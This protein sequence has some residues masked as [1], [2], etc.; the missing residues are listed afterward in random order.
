[1]TSARSSD[2]SQPVTRLVQRHGGRDFTLLF[3]SRS[4]SPQPPGITTHFQPSTQEERSSRESSSRVDDTATH[5][6]AGLQA[7]LR[8]SAHRQPIADRFP[9]R[10]HVRPQRGKLVLHDRVQPDL[11]HKCAVPA[12]PGDVRALARERAERARPRARRAVGEEIGEVKELAAFEAFGRHE[13]LQP[14]DFRDLHLKLKKKGVVTL[15]SQ[16]A[17]PMGGTTRRDLVDANV[18]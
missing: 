11:G 10:Q 6:R 18:R 14:E 9:N 16:C 17:R 8:G 4:D 7:K 3:M 5:R 1:M 15:S 13:A 2:G 12:V